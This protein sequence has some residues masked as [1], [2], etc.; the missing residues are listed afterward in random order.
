MPNLK[1]SERK[2]NHLEDKFQGLLGGYCAGV[3]SFDEVL[4]VVCC[5]IMQG[6]KKIKPS[7]L[8]GIRINRGLK[9]LYET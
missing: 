6:N 8:W 1:I 2:R 7:R 3:W 9:N 4:D 5:E